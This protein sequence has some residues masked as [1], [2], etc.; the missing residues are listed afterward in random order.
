MLRRQAMRMKRESL[1]TEVGSEEVTNFDET[2]TVV[3]NYKQYLVVFE[4]KK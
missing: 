1:R 4:W 2:F 3:L